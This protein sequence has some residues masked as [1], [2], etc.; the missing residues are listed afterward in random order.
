MNEFENALPSGGPAKPVQKST[1]PQEKIPRCRLFLL[2]T[3]GWCLLFV[4]NAL[5]RSPA[6]GLTFCIITWYI[7]LYFWKGKTLLKHSRPLL[8]VNLFLALT[9]ALGSNWYFRFWNL[10]ALV[11]LV[12]IHLFSDASLLPWWNPAMPLER[13]QR[14][15]R[16]LFGNLWS[17][18]AAM[19]PLSKKGPSK[20][21][22]ALIAGTVGS[23]ILITFLL[24][25][26]S[27]ADALFAAATAD[28]QNFIRSHFTDALGNLFWALLLTPFAFSLLYSL[29]VQRAEP[30]KART[31]PAADGLLFA[32]LLTALDILYLFFLAVQ[33]AGLFGGPAYLAERNIRYADWA[34]SGFFQMVG[35]TA[36]NLS[37]L[38]TSLTFSRKGEKS[39][40]IVRIL[41]A[42]LTAE[43][44]TLLASAA[45]RMTL[46]VTA[47]GL[48]FKRF[49][50]YWGMV[51]MALFFL[52]AA[53]KIAKPDVHFCRFAFP[54]ALAGWLIINCI[55][56]DYLVSKNQVD[57]YLN[58]ESFAIDIHYLTYSLSYDTLSQLERLDPYT[59]LSKYQGDWLSHADEPL[60]SLL[61]Q[62]KDTARRQC[63][64]WRSWSLS[65]YLAAR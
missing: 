31:L 49:M 4:D 57:R 45:W 47:Y 6:A 14:F 28:L 34:R 50:T 48:S 26:L 63:R 13:M 43:S 59:Y 18:F 46:Y 22:A 12:P 23:L 65:A 7:L 9:F 15:L 21:A 5:W 24:P 1:I 33:S 64:D 16:G 54:A 19:S 38:L 29:G 58:H 53:V 62:R 10:L 30:P 20:H 61:E 42:L 36:I 41:A 44:F 39:W 60:S 56:V 17:T 8:F 52:A 40:K 11:I 37:V 32:A 51:M 3:F 35:V 25:L 2:L 27:S 55:P